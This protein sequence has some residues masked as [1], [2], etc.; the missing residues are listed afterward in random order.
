MNGTTGLMPAGV[1]PTR[2]RIAWHRPG[3]QEA[4]WTGG[5]PCLAAFG[6]L[7]WF[8]PRGLAFVG[9]RLRACPFVFVPV[10]G[11]CLWRSTTVKIQPN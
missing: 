6:P 2:H 1:R 8:A 11:E 3:G 10:V 9:I 5:L 7:W 4:W